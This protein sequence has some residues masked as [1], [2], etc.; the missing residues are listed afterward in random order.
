M[1]LIG[2][3][4]M[5]LH[6]DEAVRAARVDREE[7]TR[8]GFGVDQLARTRSEGDN[9]TFW[10]FSVDVVLYRRSL[11]H[12]SGEFEVLTPIPCRTPLTNWTL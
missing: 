10:S 11:L 9:S 1:T 4:V 7:E 2:C 3:V 8:V 12:A 5:C 6:D